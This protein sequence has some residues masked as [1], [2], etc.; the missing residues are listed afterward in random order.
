MINLEDV[1]VEPSLG[2]DNFR[3][4]LVYKGT[5]AL[6]KNILIILFGKPGFYPSIPNLGIHIQDYRYRTF[7]E[8]NINTL[9]AQ[10]IYQCSLLKTPL[11]EGDFKIELGHLRDGNQTPVLL[12]KFKVYKS[13][14]PQD[15]LIGMRSDGD[16]VI[17]NY[18][19]YDTE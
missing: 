8:I 4:P 10:L 6:I 15:V 16:R 13:S 1:I 2:V 3:K 5:E 19:L 7:S 9:K 14:K 17:Y 11:E 12:F 18:M